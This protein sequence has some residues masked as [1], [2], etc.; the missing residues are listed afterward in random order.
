MLLMAR[1]YRGHLER[2]REAVTHDYPEWDD[3]RRRIEVASRISDGDPDVI[4]AA[5]SSG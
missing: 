2:I 3:Q 4:A 5:R 1:L